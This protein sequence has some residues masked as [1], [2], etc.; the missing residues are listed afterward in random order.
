MYIPLISDTVHCSLNLDN[1]RQLHK[2]QLY[3]TQSKTV[4]N[5]D[6]T[7]Y[8]LSYKLKYYSSPKLQKL[9]NSCSLSM[10]SAVWFS[11]L[12]YWSL[13]N[14]NMTSVALKT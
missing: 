8:R 3:I 11:S 14:V 4:L 5:L 12:V 1:A 10:F 13:I 9:S 2:G 7:T 6:Q